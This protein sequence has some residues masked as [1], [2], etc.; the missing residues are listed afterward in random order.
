M[1]KDRAARIE[2]KL[3]D[4]GIRKMM[5]DVWPFIRPELAALVL[6][7]IMKAVASVMTLLPWFALGKVVTALVAWETGD[8][9]TPIYVWA[10][11]IGLSSFVQML[12]NHYVRTRGF[13]ASERAALTARERG[14]EH[15]LQLDIA[16]HQKENSGN[17]LRR[18]EGGSDAV[19]RL[20]RIW[21]NNIIDIAVSILGVLI[22]FAQ[23][24]TFIMGASLLFLVL[25]VPLAMRFTKESSVAVWAVN[26]QTERVSGA[27]FETMNN[28][29]T[30]K[31][32][33]MSE[34]LLGLIRKHFDQM[35][36]RVKRRIEVHQG[37]QI[38]QGLLSGAFRMGAMLYILQGIF[39]GDFQAGFLVLFG[40]YFSRLTDTAL[41]STNV[42]QELEITRFS[43]ARMMD[44]LNEPILDPGT[45]PYPEDWKRL[46]LRGLSYSYGKQTA[47]VD[48]SFDIARGER[49]GIVGLSGAGKST[50]FKLLLKELGDY[51]GDVSLDGLP[52][53]D[54]RRQDYYRHVATAL[55]DTEVFNFSLRQNVEIACPEVQD[56]PVRLKRALDTAA[57]TDFTDALPRGIDTLVGEKGAKLSGGERQRLGLARAVYKE[58]DLLLLDEATSQLDVETEERVRRTLRDMYSGMTIIVVAHRLSIMKDMDRIVVLEAGR[59]AEQ[60]TFDELMS[61]K[62]RFYE[63]WQKQGI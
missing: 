24:D 15:L 47:L 44:I 17:K 16:W 53:R 62:G 46:S 6:A 41:D 19:M 30:A 20:I 8:A 38:K 39:T 58:P 49:V 48:V 40:G 11:V 29:R 10:V 42:H 23:A 26:E 56:D 45:A 2:Q 22:I 13:V 60:G 55:Q 3:N 36:G 5:S 52:L 43:I 35:H 14:V 57:V 54:I 32:L 33:G 25:Y 50:L 61:S 18:I 31:V 21:L 59:V 4:Y 51:S 37:A 27:M 7:S 1:N 28:V 9:V 34:P 12:C 63:L